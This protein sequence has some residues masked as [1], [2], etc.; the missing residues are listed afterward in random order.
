[1][2]DP[3]K[4]KDITRCNQAESMIDNPKS[5]QDKGFATLVKRIVLSQADQDQD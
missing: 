1:M 3:S 4:V 2:N 5:D